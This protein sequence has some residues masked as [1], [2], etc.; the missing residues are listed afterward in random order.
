MYEQNTYK[1]S[2]KFNAL[3]IVLMF[4]SMLAVG[5]LL[6]WLY[7]IIKDAIP[8]I[9]LNILL[10]LGVSLALGAI[11][12]FFIKVYKIRA[13][14]LA[15][16]VSL[17]ALIFVNYGKW[18]VYVARDYD[19]MIY[20]DLKD[21]KVS[22]LYE[23]ITGKS[24]DL[25][26]TEEEANEFL[27]AVSLGKTINLKQEFTKNLSALG[28][29]GDTDQI[30]SAITIITN[31]LGETYGDILENLLGSSAGEIL[32]NSEKIRNSTNMSVYEYLYEYRGMQVRSSFWLM[33]H[34]GELFEDIKNINSVGRWTIRS[35]RYGF[36]DNQSDNISGFLLWMVWAGELAM[37]IIPAMV[38]ISKKAKYPFIE[39]ENDWAVEDKPMPQFMWGDMLGVSSAMVKNNVL[40]DPDY[41][42]EMPK[43]TVTQSIPDKYYTLT[44]CRSKYFDEIYI[45]LNYVT[46]VNPRKN[47]KKTTPL[48]INLKVDAD[49]LATLYGTFEYSVPPLCQG[50]NRAEEI[51]KDNKERAEN[52]KYG[53][54]SAPT[55][56]K[57]TG[58]E[59]IFDEPLYSR[60]AMKQQQQTT[61]AEE[62][63]KQEQSSG[64]PTS[65][66]MDGIDTSSLNLD[67]IDLTHM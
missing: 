67:D 27:V 17:I 36:G 57:A 65:G 45:T 14:K 7:L 42:F 24:F 38:M 60:Q 28:G 44:Y 35:H 53:R 12:A 54:P 46:V 62:Q 47:Q 41:I 26:K 6:S 63:M 29:L 10:C 55:P 50:T 18:A 48:V 8:L 39:S 5:F 25:P 49:F 9:Y 19:D 16:I 66:D 34:P 37:L 52:A 2:N 1:P 21:R 33:S 58:A 40:R 51:K 3:G 4:L 23:T 11:G 59:A 15:I 56:P 64:K 43:I 22:E 32:T 31:V 30:L 13:P 20:S 61:F